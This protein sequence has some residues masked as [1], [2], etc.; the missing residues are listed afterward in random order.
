LQIPKKEEK[1]K[2]RKKVSLGCS[3]FEA[4]RPLHKKSAACFSAA[5]AVHTIEWIANLDW[6]I[7][8]ITRVKKSGAK[9]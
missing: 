4:I 2:R 7:A 8:R 1:A 5:D 6:S 3:F 9:V